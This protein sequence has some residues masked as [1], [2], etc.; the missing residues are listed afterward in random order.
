[1]AASSPCLLLRPILKTKNMAMKISSQHRGEFVYTGATFRQGRLVRLGASE[2]GTECGCHLGLI[3][4]LCKGRS[5]YICS[6]PNALRLKWVENTYIHPYI[7]ICLLVSSVGI[8]ML[9]CRCLSL[10]HTKQ[11]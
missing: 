10:N 3:L 5:T 4:G 6:H 2:I 7:Y 9:I 8:S 11:T 1:M